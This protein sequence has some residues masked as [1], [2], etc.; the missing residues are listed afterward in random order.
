MADTEQPSG[1][2]SL[3]AMNF[4]VVSVD[5]AIGDKKKQTG[6][7][8]L[9]K[10]KD[11]LHSIHDAAFPRGVGPAM[12]A[13]TRLEWDNIEGEVIGFVLSAGLAYGT[14][15]I[16]EED[17]LYTFATPY[18]CICEMLGKAMAEAIWKRRHIIPSF[19]AMVENLNLLVIS[20]KGLGREEQ[21]RMLQAV[22]LAISEQ[23]RTEGTPQKGRLLRGM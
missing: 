19:D 14:P 18:E 2:H 12:L 3:A 21:I 1:D 8:E 11:L 20:L 10:I 5:E 13:E 4:G 6:K 17:D 16:Q 7:P 9:S 15:F 22:S 23:E